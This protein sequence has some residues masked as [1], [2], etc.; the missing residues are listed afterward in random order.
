M[1]APAALNTA[2]VE[3]TRNLLGDKETDLLNE[4]VKCYV[5]ESDITS[6]QTK[7]AVTESNASF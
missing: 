5:V 2:P 1:A 6:A 7:V 3:Y 4:P